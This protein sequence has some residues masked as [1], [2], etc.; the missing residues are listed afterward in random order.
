[1]NTPLQPGLRRLGSLAASL[2]L[3]A[4]LAACADGSSSQTPDGASAPPAA[5]TTQPVTT[6][7][8]PA[9]DPGSPTNPGSPTAPTP[10]TNPG[11]PTS[12]TPPPDPTPPTN[13]TP[14]PVSTPP[15]AA[16]GSAAISWTAP[17]SAVD[18][19]TI[20]TLAGFEILYGNS[21]SELTQSLQVANPTVTTYTVPDLTSGTWYFSVQAYLA[22]GTT[23]AASNPASVVVP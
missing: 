18:G 5:S 3:A 1:M 7:S 16:N 14:P 4:V 21:P 20:T 10:P 8:D 9:P 22:D 23:S 2:G 11:S 13:P 15:P 19:T 12:P 17:T 6:P